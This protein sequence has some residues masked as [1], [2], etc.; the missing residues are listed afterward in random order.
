MEQKNFSDLLKNLRL[1]K[2]WSQEEACEGVCDRRTYIRWEKGISEPSDYYLHLLS[3]RFN[4]DLQ[5]YYKVFIC[6]K[7]MSVFTHKQEAYR[8]ISGSNWKS[9][10]EFTDKIQVLPEFQTGEALQNIIYFKALY[11]LK[12][13]EN[14]SLSINYCLEGLQIENNLVTLNNPTEKIFS[15]V[16]IC[17]L[18]C[19]ASTLTMLDKKEEAIKIYIGIM[20]NIEDKIIPNISH[21]QSVEFEKNI[22]QVTAYNIGYS[23]QFS[24]EFR[25]ALHYVNRGI[26]FSI[27]HHYLNKLAKLLE[28]KFK[29]LYQIEEYEE[30]KQTF[31]QCMSLNLLQNKTKQYKHGL[32]DLYSIYPKI[33]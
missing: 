4:Y 27:Q 1:Q 6:N 3:Y 30:A 23:Y 15:N 33:L 18:N 14:Y 16:G 13:E 25:L 28:L 32:E 20:A 22:Y 5:A 7:S 31:S 21:Y 10:K 24:K 11:A 9:L 12:F 29:I 8:Y 17:T 2:N 26:D 19:L